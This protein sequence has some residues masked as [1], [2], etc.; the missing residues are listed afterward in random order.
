MAGEVRVRVTADASGLRKGMQEAGEHVEDFART[1]KKAG[2]EGREFGEILSVLGGV[3]EG[4]GK[5]VGTLLTGLAS[6]SVIGAAAA[7]VA[8]L[9]E[10]FREAGKAAEEA[11]KK[12]SA[13]GE[14]LAKKV[15]EAMQK[16]RVLTLV[17]GG[18]SE[19][20]A[21]QVVAEQDAIGVQRLALTQLEETRQ[22]IVELKK[23]SEAEAAARRAGSFSAN[24]WAVTYAEDIAAAEAEVKRLESAIQSLGTVAE[25]M[26]AEGSTKTVEEAR[27]AADE[28]EKARL[29]AVAKANAAYGKMM[30]ERGELYLRQLK[31]EVDAAEKAEKDKAKAGQAA[32]DARARKFE[33]SQKDSE[34]AAKDDVAYARQ[35]GEAYANV[36]LNASNS[37]EVMGGVL[38]TTFGTIID[39][40]EKQILADAAAA[41]AEAYKSQ[42]GIPIIG[43]LLAAGASATAFAV[44]KGF[45]GKLPGREQGGSVRAGQPYVVGEKR[46]EVFVPD[47]AGTILPSTRG[48]GGSSVRIGIT[49][50]DA[51]SFSRSSRS[52][53]R[54]LVKVIREAQRD[55]VR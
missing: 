40:I 34:N 27:K 18:M 55:G 14:T 30:N 10:H 5:A 45:L 4:A 20:Q 22:K 9:V 17:Q 28:V 48:L 41:A 47:Q 16:F 15:D 53:R 2:R 42:A 11:E 46:P 38:K 36:F 52:L 3:S 6:G 33:K 35:V 21:K 13:F 31:A 24:I 29:A 43:P 44:V 1:A 19:A 54:E 23:A 32:L 8:A 12:A 50:M 26:G 25:G 39:L 7:A 37:A 49:A 51:R